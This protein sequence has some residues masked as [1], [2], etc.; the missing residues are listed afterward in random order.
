MKGKEKKNIDKIICGA[1]FVAGVILLLVEMRI[2]SSVYLFKMAR[3]AAR[4]ETEYSMM[5]NR[6]F[7]YDRDNG[8]YAF[9]LSRIDMAKK[10]Y[11]GAYKLA[12]EGKKTYT[13][14]QSI[15]QIGSILSNLGN[16]QESVE[17]FK[18]SLF[19]YPDAEETRLR[20]GI[21]S[22]QKGDNN[23]AKEYFEYLIKQNPLNPNPY[24]FLGYME[25]SKGD[26]KIALEFFK[27]VK[28]LLKT[29]RGEVWFEK[30]NFDDL[31]DKS[32]QEAGI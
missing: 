12:M 29:N 32:K 13:S 2:T 6:A 14:I 4:T 28:L 18:K 7:K 11:D 20:L 23:T 16:E 8:Y 1:I 9:F 27:S 10:D 26:K 15:A 17:C 30:G 5:L 19:L 25:Y 21:I 24:Y 31:Y 3:G 22:L